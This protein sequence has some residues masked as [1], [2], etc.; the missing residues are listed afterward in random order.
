MPHYDYAC[1]EC[2]HEFETFQ[3][4]SEPPLEQCPSCGG[5]VKRKIGGG[6]GIIFKGSGFYVTDY[7]KTSCSEGKSEAK[8]EGCSQ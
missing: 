8:C 5:K 4:M 6:M 1:L 7:K 3:M 2:K